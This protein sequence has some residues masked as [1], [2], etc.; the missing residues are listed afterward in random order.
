MISFRDLVAWCVGLLL[1]Q[2]AQAGIPIQHWTQPSGAQVFLVESAAI[3]MLDVQVD[4]DA[5]NRR[6]PPD[7]AGL[8]DVRAEYGLTREAPF[9]PMVPKVSELVAQELVVQE[10]L[11]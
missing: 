2:V 1:L 9:V 4:F 10:N 7:Q 11:R 8:A 6:D 3:P 5:G